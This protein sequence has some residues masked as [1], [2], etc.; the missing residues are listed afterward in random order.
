YLFG[1][2]VLFY[3]IFLFIYCFYCC[4]DYLNDLWK[5]DGTNW[6]WLSGSNTTKQRATFGKKVVPHPDNVPGVRNSAVSWIDSKNNLYLFGGY[7]N[8]EFRS[9]DRIY[10]LSI[11]FTVVDYVND[12]WKFDGSNWTWIAGSSSV[13]PKGTYGT[14]DVP[15]PDNVPGGR[16]GAVS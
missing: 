8:D 6:T 1:G 5:F 3:S 16:Y 7:A 11:V 2:S 13:S 12:L 15:D 4:L 10:C 9:S 14:K